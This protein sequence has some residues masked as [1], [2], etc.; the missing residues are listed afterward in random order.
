MIGEW[1]SEIL[2]GSAMAAWVKNSLEAGAAGV[3]AQ[4]DE[5]ILFLLGL[6]LT[7]LG[8]WGRKKICRGAQIDG[9]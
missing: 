5:P 1:L 2:T 4:G 3:L 9:R 7:G 8:I 6:G